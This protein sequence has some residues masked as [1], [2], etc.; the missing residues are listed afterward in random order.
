MSLKA[1]EIRGFQPADTPYRK[2][3]QNGLYLEIRPNGSKLW[4]CKF[5]IQGI[6]KRLS[7]GH[8]ID[9]IDD[10]RAH[11][12]GAVHRH[13]PDRPASDHRDAAA[14]HDIGIARAEPRSRECVGHQQCLFFGHAIGDRHRVDVRGW[15]AHRLGLRSLQFCGQAIAARHAI[16]TQ[17]DHAR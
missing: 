17:V 15:H 16:L 3:D 8:R 13:Q 6:E 9:R 2:T 5:R 1:A 7:L 4:Y 12:E 11:H 10:M 14:R